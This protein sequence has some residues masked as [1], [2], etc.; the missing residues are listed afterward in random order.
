M[1]Y[2]I[3][4]NAAIVVLLLLLIVG[5]N[6]ND[7][8]RSQ[9][10]AKVQH[11]HPDFEKHLLETATALKNDLNDIKELLAT[12]NCRCDCESSH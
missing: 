9:F 11:Q 2:K 5:I 10:E 3:Y 7:H 6:L 12:R 8:R 4:L 1:D